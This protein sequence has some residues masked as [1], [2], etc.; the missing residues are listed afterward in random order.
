MGDLIRRAYRIQ[1]DGKYEEFLRLRDVEERAESLFNGGVQTR[2]ESRHI[3][4]TLT[5]WEPLAFEDTL[6][7]RLGYEP[8]PGYGEPAEAGEPRD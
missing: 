8:F 7:G 2:I 3:E 5:D 4:P 1:V 6:P